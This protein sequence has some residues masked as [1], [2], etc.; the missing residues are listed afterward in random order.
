VKTREIITTLLLTFFSLCQAQ[1]YSLK[2]YRFGTAGGPVA[3]GDLHGYASLGETCI[4]TA[5]DNTYTHTAGFLKPKFTSVEQQP[6]LLP[7]TF[8]LHQNYPNPFNS[9]TS[10][11]FELPVPAF[12]QL[13]IYDVQGRLV[14]TLMNGVRPA[15]YHSIS[16]NGTSNTGYSLPS[17]I[18][19]Y[20]MKADRFA[21]IK[22]LVI[23]K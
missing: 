13:R 20:V 4:G 6:D 5:T 10:I 23:T 16:W 9:S 19:V 15:G 11:R 1:E 8:K 17:G 12:V 14:S 7:Q 2:S 22:K 3:S 21:S 18:Y